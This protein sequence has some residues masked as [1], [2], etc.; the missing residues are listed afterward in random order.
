MVGGERDRVLPHAVEAR[1]TARGDP[2]ADHDRLV[3]KH[4]G[5]VGKVDAE[6]GSIEDRVKD[7]VSHQH[8]LAGA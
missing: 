3:L 2:G 8:G 1:T 6:A 7:I 4:H 5:R